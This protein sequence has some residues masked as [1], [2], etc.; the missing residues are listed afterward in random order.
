MTPTCSSPELRALL[1]ACADFRADTPPDDPL[2]QASSIFLR[3]ALKDPSLIEQA[4]I[5]LEELSPDAISWMALIFGSYAENGG[6]AD[7]TVTTL[8]GHLRDWCDKLPAILSEEDGLPD[9]DEAQTALLRAAPFLCQSIVGHLGRLPQTQ[10]TLA[11]DVTLLERLD[12]L[13][14]Y[15]HGFMWVYEALTRWS[16]P[17]LILHVP[18]GAGMRLQ[19]H[20]V[21]NCFHLFSLIQCAVGK[22][23]PGGQDPDPTLS[24]AAH[25][26]G[27]ESCSD[28][29]WWH[30]GN[31][32]SPT[33]AIER[34]IWG[35][36]HPSTIPCI[37]GNPVIL[38]WP[39]LLSSRS[40]DS[41]FFGP[42]LDAMP[43]GV[44]VEE[45][46]STPVCQAWF[47]QLSLPWPANNDQ[48][49]VTSR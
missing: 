17:L 18:S 21:S 1:D 32:L 45:I 24:A 30:Y 28:H 20:H 40:W 43:A 8:V 38:L 23:L 12:E 7:L 46:L 9:P 29:A 26:E 13:G 4:I 14:D 11:K 22:R 33:P 10:A 44:V 39:S 47:E 5:A 41:G 2:R 42:H 31:P 49:S 35:E 34:S 15:S 37:D 16:S 48:A 27:L 36:A 25:G 6:R 3:A 19:I